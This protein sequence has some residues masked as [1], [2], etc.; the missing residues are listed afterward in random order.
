MRNRRAKET[1]K[2]GF[3]M[4]KIDFPDELFPVE[5]GLVFSEE[6]GSWMGQKAVNIAEAINCTEV[7]GEVFILG[8]G[9]EGTV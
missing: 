9:S 7:E 5:A 3:G 1:L 2:A 6:I 4:G 8:N